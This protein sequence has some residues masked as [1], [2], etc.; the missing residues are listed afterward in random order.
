[1]K[2]YRCSKPKNVHK[3]AR[4]C[5]N[6]GLFIEGW[7]AQKCFQDP[8]RIRLISVLPKIGWAM[9]DEKKYQ[10][11]VKPEHRRK[12]YGT[13]L[14]RSVVNHALSEGKNHGNGTKEGTKFFDKFWGSTYYTHHICRNPHTTSKEG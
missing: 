2:M 6:N 1:M 4:H 12:G 14:L 11:F 10:V 7:W 9:V 5:L 13:R 3:L 8:V